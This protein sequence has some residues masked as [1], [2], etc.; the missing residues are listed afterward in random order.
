MKRI[1]ELARQFNNGEIDEKAFRSSLIAQ[2][3]MLDDTGTLLLA[4]YLL[5]AEQ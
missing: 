2:I 1:M 5:R 4:A 3:S